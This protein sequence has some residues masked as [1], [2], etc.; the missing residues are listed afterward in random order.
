MRTKNSASHG[1]SGG[2][3]PMK[4]PLVPSRE[5]EMSSSN[6]K[7]AFA[8]TGIWPLNQTKVMNSGKLVY[9]KDLKIPNVLVKSSFSLTVVNNLE[10]LSPRSR[11]HL[12]NIEMAAT[13][14][15]IFQRAH[16]QHQKQID[17]LS[18]FKRKPSVTN[19]YQNTIIYTTL[20]LICCS[21]YYG[22]AVRCKLF[23]I[24]SHCDVVR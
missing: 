15:A 7:S 22:V 20:H 10:D 21:K 8:A 4:P 16:N 3:H 6:I 13:G 9:E 19:D 12:V 5:I 24:A 23:A 18:T 2:L 17:L 1:L 14:E 11:R